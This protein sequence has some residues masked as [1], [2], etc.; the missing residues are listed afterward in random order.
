[1]GDSSGAEDPAQRVWQVV[2]VEGEEE[3][4]DLRIANLHLPS[5]RQLGAEASAAKRISEVDDVLAYEP[6]VIV[7]DWNEK[8]GGPLTELMSSRGFVDAAVVSGREDT[9]SSIGGGRGDQIWVAKGLASRLVGYGAVDVS[10]FGVEDVEGKTHVSDHLPIWIDL[11]DLN[12]D[13]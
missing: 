5:S 4:D 6:D 9:T 12:A 3:S 13:V 11:G 10:D 1:M 8:P 2:D 7:G